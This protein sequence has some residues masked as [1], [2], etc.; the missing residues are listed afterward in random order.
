MTSHDR[1]T[2]TFARLTGLVYLF[3]ALIGGS[4]YFL[5]SQSLIIP[6]NAA[7]TADNIRG[8]M[9]LLRLGI[10]A[11]LAILALDI[12]MTW[13]LFHLFANTNKPL[14]MLAAWMRLAYVFIHGAAVLNLASILNIAEGGLRA[15]P[16]DYQNDMILQYAEAH[17]DG[18]MISLMF[19]GIHLLLISYLIWK[20]G[21]LP[22]AL[23]AFLSIAG[24]AYICDTLAMVLLPNY[25]QL[26][27]QI[28]PFVAI[29]AMIGEIG[30]LLWLL[31]MGVKSRA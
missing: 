12:L 28:E 4:A 5:V 17:L 22:K 26:Q 14:S 23:G 25:A 20:S 13:M 19:F 1:A 18:F 27:P 11:Y 16:S 30:L 15:M 9:S 6:G 10:T 21:L 29:A 7:Q 24:I 3:I 8:N 31:I 2:P